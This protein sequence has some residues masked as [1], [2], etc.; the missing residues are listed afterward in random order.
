[1]LE[2]DGVHAGYGRSTVLHGVSMTVPAGS[3]VAGTRPQ[4]CRQEH[5]AACRERG[6]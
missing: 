5:A 2:I 3:V 1:M 4:R 6:C